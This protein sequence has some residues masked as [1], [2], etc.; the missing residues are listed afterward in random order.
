MI[1]SSFRVEEKNTNK[2]KNEPHIISDESSD[3]NHNCQNVQPQGDEEHIPSTLRGFFF[4]FSGWGGR[5]FC[6]WLNIEIIAPED[7]RLFYHLSFRII[8]TCAVLWRRDD[9][10]CRGWSKL[11]ISFL[12]DTGVL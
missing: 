11:S 6:V 4:F 10:A 8:F 2:N 7:Y 12:D 5:M 1:W 9:K 3:Y